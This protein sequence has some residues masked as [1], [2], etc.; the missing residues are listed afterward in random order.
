MPSVDHYSSLRLLPILSPNFP[1]TL[2]VVYLYFA[3]I[4]KYRVIRKSRPSVRD[5]VLSRVECIV[6]DEVDRLIDAL[7]RH[8]SP[9]D[10][11]RRKRHARPISALLKR[12]IEAK[13]GV[14]VSVDDGQSL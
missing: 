10:V 13:P 3:D 14:Q 6:V 8:A 4:H 11:D 9:R 5:D 7:P 2:L 1:R 12:V